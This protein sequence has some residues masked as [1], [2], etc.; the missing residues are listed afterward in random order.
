MKTPTP[1][2]APASVFV[3]FFGNYPKIRVLEYIVENARF[4]FS[5]R[6]V[7]EG[8]EVSWNTLQKLWPQLENFEMTKKTRKLGKEQLY[9]LDLKSVLAQALLKIHH[10]LLQK[11]LAEFEAHAAKTK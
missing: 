7:C 2:P 6:A 3:E 11:A 8:A 5:K 10:L 4:D 1:P 9:A